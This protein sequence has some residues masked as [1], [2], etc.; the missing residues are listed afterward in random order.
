MSRVLR[1]LD[2]VDDVKYTL[3]V[4][5]ATVSGQNPDDN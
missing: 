1:G 2:L 5:Q 4:Q 3:R